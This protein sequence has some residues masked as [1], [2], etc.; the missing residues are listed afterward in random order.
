M[1][2]MFICIP[3]ISILVVT[4]HLPGLTLGFEPARE[5]ETV[6]NKITETTSSLRVMMA[7]PLISAHS[8]T[9]FFGLALLAIS[10]QPSAKYTYIQ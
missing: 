7:P 3:G 8:K 2:G 5:S 1:G 10:V 6:A 4:S 9:M